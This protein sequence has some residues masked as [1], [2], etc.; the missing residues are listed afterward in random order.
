MT[1]RSPSNGNSGIANEIRYN[2]DDP[3]DADLK[4]TGYNGI[5]ESA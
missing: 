5:V 2:R 3:E 4:I 1:T